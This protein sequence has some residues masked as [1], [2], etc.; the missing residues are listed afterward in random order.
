MVRQ[1]P[2]PREVL[3][4]HG[5]LMRR[6]GDM[7]TLISEKMG[8]R[9]R[10]TVLVL[11][12]IVTAIHAGCGQSASR[13]QQPKYN[14]DAGT[15]ALERFDTNHDGVISGTEFNAVPSLKSAMPRIDQNHDGSLSADEINRAVHT[16]IDSHLA[17]MPVMAFVNLDGRPLGDAEITLEPEEFLGESVQTAHGK[18]DSD[19]FTTL[20]SADTHGHGVQLGWYRVILSKKNGERETVPERFNSKSELGLEVTPENAMGL[21]H[22]TW[23]LSSRK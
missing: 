11:G 2:L 9:I 10:S 21:Q 3:K 5:S 17:L 22:L 12:L 8:R 4:V 19:G 16:W 20:S 23:D 6:G 15:A 14:R 7:A 18:T 13:V 1:L